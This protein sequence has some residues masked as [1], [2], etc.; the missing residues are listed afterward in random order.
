M[1]RGRSGSKGRH[2]MAAE[3][4]T[5]RAEG[6]AKQI[7]PGS[8]SCGARRSILR[9]TSVGPRRTFR[10]AGAVPRRRGAF[11][12]HCR[13]LAGLTSPAAGVSIFLAAG[14]RR[15]RRLA[16]CGYRDVGEGRLCCGTSRPEGWDVTKA[17]L[18]YSRLF[19]VVF[20]SRVQASDRRADLRRCE[21]EFHCGPGPYEF[22]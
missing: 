15:S 21:R 9:A 5:R 3:T 10:K 12:S 4:S 8:N 2:E 18:P 7:E 1:R 20:R 16:S 22:L 17:A 6:P 13:L 11:F 14:S 19:S